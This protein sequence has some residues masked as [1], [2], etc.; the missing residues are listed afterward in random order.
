M[1]ELYYLLECFK[2]SQGLKMIH[3]V[4]NPQFYW[5]EDQDLD[6]LKNII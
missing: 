4:L 1:K 6:I 5:N 2:N 3:K